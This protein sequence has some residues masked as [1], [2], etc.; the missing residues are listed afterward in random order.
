MLA[1]TSIHISSLKHIDQEGEAVFF[2]KIQKAFS[3][4]SS[5]MPAIKTKLPGDENQN[6]DIT[7][8]D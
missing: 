7:L 6:S 1:V 2:L 3:K 5:P 8:S 4:V